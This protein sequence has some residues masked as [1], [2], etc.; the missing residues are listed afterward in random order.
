LVPPDE[1]TS[2][3]LLATLNILIGEWTMD[4]Q[5]P[6][7]PPSGPIGSTVFKW[8]L[9]DKFVTQRGTVH[10]PDVPDVFAL[11]GLNAIGG[12]FTQHYFDS[13]GVV[14]VYDMTL[15]ENAWH[16]HREAADFTPLDFAQRFTGL[17]SDD[18]LA[19]EGAWEIRH[20]N[21]TW[22]HDFVLKYHKVS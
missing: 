18:G 6:G 20:D 7:A 16:L 2:G 5:F 9:D 1:R 22:N 14:R 8:T 12:G 21:S 13:R 4:A 15:S 3:D 19:I 17:I 10:H 11:I